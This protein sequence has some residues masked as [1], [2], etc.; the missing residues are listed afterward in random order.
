LKESLSFILYTGRQRKKRKEKKGK[1][2]GS[3][4]IAGHFG[5]ASGMDCSR[6]R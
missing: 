6:A 5:V 4:E 3:E 1:G 2:K